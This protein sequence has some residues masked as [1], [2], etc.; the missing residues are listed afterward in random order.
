MKETMLRHVK[1]WVTV[2]FVF[3]IV[4][5]ILYALFANFSYLDTDKGKAFFC[6]VLLIMYF[7]TTF[8]EVIAVTWK[9]HRYP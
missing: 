5:V 1:T 6:L 4:A 2:A 3:S 8:T 9:D 7:A